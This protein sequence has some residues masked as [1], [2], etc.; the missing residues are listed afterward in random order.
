V[1]ASS[2]DA[3]KKAPRR[4]EATFD[5]ATPRAIHAGFLKGRKDSD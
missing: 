3:A 1:D 5:V 2:S 4:S